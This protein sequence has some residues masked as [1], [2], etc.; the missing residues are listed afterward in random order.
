MSYKKFIAFFIFPSI[1][2]FFTFSFVSAGIP[3]AVT[4][5][6]AQS[7]DE[8]I[9]QALVAAGSDVGDITYL[10]EFSGTTATD[11][12]K[13]ILAIVAVGENPRTF[14]STDLVDG[15]AG[16]YD[17]TQL[18]SADLL[19][20]DIW[21][22]LALRSAGYTVGAQVVQ[23]SKNFILQNQNVDGGWGY[24]V[25][26]DSDTNDTAAA[27]VSLV[28]AGIAQDD[29]VIQ[30]ALIYLKSVQN[31]DG[32]FPYSVGS[33]SDGGSDAW[34][35]WAFNKLGTSLDEW[36]VDGG[37]TPKSHLESLQQENGG[38]LW[39]ISDGNI[40]TNITAHAVVALT[41]KSFP[42][43]YVENAE[44]QQFQ[45]RIEGSTE[46]VCDKNISGTTA[47]E[48]VRNAAD[49]CGFTYVIEDTSFGPY[50]KTIG[51]DMAEGSAGWM[52]WVNWQSPSVGAA[53][54]TL[55]TGDE[56]LWAYGTWGNTILTRL[57]VDKTHIQEQEEVMVIVEALTGDPAAWQ[58]LEGATVYCGNDTTTAATDEY[59]KFP[60]RCLTPKWQIWAEKAG[61]IRSNTVEVVI[62]GVS[63]EVDLKV[64]IVG[65][66]DDGGA[67]A[68][69]LAFTVSGGQ[70]HFGALKPGEKGM[71]DLTL[72]NTGTSD[73]YIESIVEGNEIF[74]DAL[75]VASQLWPLYETHI[76][77]SE[78]EVVVVS[79]PVPDDYTSY[80]EKNG[81]LIFWGTG[82][83]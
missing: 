64:D 16:L 78:E 13:R 22:I 68:P 70:V 39:T 12:A 14:A 82:I 4:Y 71:V 11:Y 15:L 5:L 60:L 9:T 31:S 43:A 77:K 27:V 72:T 24:A 17:G 38:Y 51:S 6:Q 41:G 36:V 76:Q 18:G 37:A 32:G 53:D 33:E 80:G 34:V 29:A 61:H 50:L 66:G 74:T 69:E 28:E 7:A 42:L 52:Y 23:Q 73:L 75:Y 65:G 3:E 59:G 40:Y 10:Q 25:G 47:L 81:T 20:D 44:E 62:G 58:P 35:L 46:T 30:N 1:L 55:Q 54:Y 48:V 2:L 79:L 63:Q 45:V 57:T 21:G 8:W 19:N 67:H 56:V 26:S 49:L 83:E